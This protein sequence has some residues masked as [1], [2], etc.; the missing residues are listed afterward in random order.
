MDPR[1]AE[2]SR[3]LDRYLV[4]IVER[5]DLCPWAKSARLNGEVAREVLW[6]QPSL[7]AWVDAG[8]RLLAAPKARVAMVIAPEFQGSLTELRAVRTH[9]STAIGD[10]GVAEFHPDADLDLASPSRLVRFLR[11]SPDPM[12]QL[13]PLS[14]LDSVRGGDRIHIDQ[15]DQVALLRGELV[16]PVNI[17][18]QIA[19]QNHASITAATEAV[20]AKLAHIAADRAA[21]YA[22]VGINTSR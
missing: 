19:D 4:E 3:L 8:R 7:E 13:V 2:V 6:G 20:V 21:S 22:R 1:Q 11:R 5:Y 15:L 18:E 16:L 10:A 12:M 17:G 14:I 9:V